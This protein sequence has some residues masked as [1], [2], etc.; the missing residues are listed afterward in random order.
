MWIWSP[1]IKMTLHACLLR[2]ALDLEGNARHASPEKFKGQKEM[3]EVVLLAQ[4]WATCSYSNN[5]S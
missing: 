3:S 2:S 1:Q 5:L 4:P